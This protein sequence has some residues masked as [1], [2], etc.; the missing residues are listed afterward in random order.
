MGVGARREVA[1]L[2]RLG[3]SVTC[4]TDDRVVSNTNLTDELAR[5]AT[6]L[7]LTRQELT[8]AAPVCMRARQRRAPSRSPMMSQPFAA[9]AKAARVGTRRVMSDKTCRTSSGRP[10]LA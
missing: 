10:E 5:S 3:V 1:R 9:A 2:H 4:S 8:A 7:S 6:R